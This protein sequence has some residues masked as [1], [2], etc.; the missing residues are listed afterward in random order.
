M[1]HVSCSHNSHGRLL[2]GLE[3]TRETTAIKNPRCRCKVLSMQDAKAAT[4]LR[5]R[6]RG[7]ARPGHDILYAIG[8]RTIERENTKKLVEF[9]GGWQYLASS[10]VGRAGA[11]NYR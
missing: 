9:G 1:I 4:L 3:K 8:Q 5:G 11:F 6:I 10:L 2:Q 7:S